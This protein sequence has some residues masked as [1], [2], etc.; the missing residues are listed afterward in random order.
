MEVVRV[1]SS[2]GGNVCAN[3]LTRSMALSSRWSLMMNRV[4]NEEVEG[5]GTHEER[6]RIKARF[7][8]STNRTRTLNISSWTLA[9]F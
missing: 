9:S 7:A 5:E 4:S 2:L 3:S 1:R 6:T 8:L